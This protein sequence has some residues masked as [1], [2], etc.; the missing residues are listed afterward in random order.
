[1]ASAAP[2]G[3]AVPASTASRSGELIVVGG[4]AGQRVLAVA[5]VEPFA[6]RVV[7][8]RQAGVVELDDAVIALD[9]QEA[10]EG[11]VHDVGDEGRGDLAREAQVA[12]TRVSAPRSERRA[13][14][15]R[16][17][18]SLP[19]KLR[20]Q[21]GAGPAGGDGADLDAAAAAHRLDDRARRDAGGSE[22]ADRMHWISRQAK[23]A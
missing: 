3:R 6:Q 17:S 13:L 11:R 1:M 9:A 16:I 4:A 21:C 14:A 12:S 23:K 19:M 20:S 22:N 18:G 10:A 7:F 15:V 2:V 8:V 5:V